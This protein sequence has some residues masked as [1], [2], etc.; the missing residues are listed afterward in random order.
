MM[1]P[2]CACTTAGLCGAALEAWALLAGSRAPAAALDL[3]AQQ[4]HE[5]MWCKVLALCRAAVLVSRSAGLFIW[6]GTDAWAAG[7]Q[8]SAPPLHDT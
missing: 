2:C 3:V 5:S 6:I 1:C 8:L 4:C 7:G